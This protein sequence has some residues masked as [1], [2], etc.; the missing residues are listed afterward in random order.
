MAYATT[1][2]PQKLAGTGPTGI[3]FWLYNH[4]TD[5]AATVRAAGYFSN[6]QALGMRVGD[7]VIHHEAST[8]L[9]SISIVTVVASTGSTLTA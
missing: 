8:P 7:I 3:Q 4:A 2:P 9:G 5:N 6:A 1:N